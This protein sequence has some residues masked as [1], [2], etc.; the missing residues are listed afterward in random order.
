[1]TK[2]VISPAARKDLQE[3]GDYIALK[4]HNKA[5]ARNLIGRIHRAVT[6]LK[7]F[8]ESGAPLRFPAIQMQ[9]RY[10]I[11]GNY[12]IFYH[13]SDESA[14]VDRILYGRRDYLSILFSDELSEE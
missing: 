11:C 9:Y 2:V 6:A 1:M 4:L 8:P 13:L 3:I 12:M 14:C 5:A 10:L 7:Q